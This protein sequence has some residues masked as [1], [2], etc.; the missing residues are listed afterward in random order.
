MCFC[1][2][3]P[4]SSSWKTGVNMLWGNW[5]RSKKVK[6]QFGFVFPINRPLKVQ[7]RRLKPAATIDGRHG[8]RGPWLQVW[9][10]P[11]IAG[12]GKGAAILL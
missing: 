7:G 3:N 10:V 8:D 6:V 9:S 4:N 1:G 5:M 11:F 12:Q 2:T